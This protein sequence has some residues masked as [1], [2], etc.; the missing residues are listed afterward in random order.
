MHS[1]SANRAGNR[2]RLDYAWRRK[3]ILLTKEFRVYYCMQF[4]M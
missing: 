4:C 1:L 2:A 3:D